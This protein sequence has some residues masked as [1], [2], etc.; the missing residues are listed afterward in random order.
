MCGLSVVLCAALQLL[1]CMLRTNSMVSVS[2][3]DL[4]PGSGLSP[5]SANR[6]PGGPGRAGEAPGA[7]Q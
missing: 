2:T 6:A 1:T 5:M 4:T 3:S 7:E